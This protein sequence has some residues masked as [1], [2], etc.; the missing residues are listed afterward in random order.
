M[1]EALPAPGDHAAKDPE[2]VFPITSA[3]IRT[4][5]PVLRSPRGKELPI[6]QPAAISQDHHI[7]GRCL[8]H[9]LRA[10]RRRTNRAESQGQREQPAEKS[11]GC[12]AS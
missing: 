11:H 8:H 4:L 10:G 9:L 3:L 12:K 1:L 7:A 5:D 6:P 2:A